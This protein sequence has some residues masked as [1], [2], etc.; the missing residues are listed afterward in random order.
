MQK[1]EARNPYDHDRLVFLVDEK[2]RIVER[3][4]K[5][6]ITRVEFKND[7]T[8]NIRHYQKKKSA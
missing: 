2:N 8:V 6:W 1:K 4:E 5:G 3:F 7:G